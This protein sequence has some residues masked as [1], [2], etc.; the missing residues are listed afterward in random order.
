MSLIG[1]RPLVQVQPG[2]LHL[3]DAIVFGSAGPGIAAMGRMSV[4]CA[5]GIG[6]CARS[7]GGSWPVSP[8]VALPGV[9]ASGREHAIRVR[10]RV[11]HDR[12]AYDRQ[13]DGHPE[14]A[15]PGPSRRTWG[16]PS[17][18]RRRSRWLVGLCILAV[19]VVDAHRLRLGSARDQR[20]L[21]RPRW[22]GSPGL[23]GG[24]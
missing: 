19:Q 18:A 22:G 14:A 23:T 1:M 8:K 4:G 16:Q 7:S 20:W 2:P 9:A 5:A 13:P 3:I 15:I 21:E 11:T 6:L 24:G 17:S 12:L 10:A